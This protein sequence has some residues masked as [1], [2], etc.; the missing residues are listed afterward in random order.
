MPITK[1]PQRDSNFKNKIEGRFNTEVSTLTRETERRGQFEKLHMNNNQ[2]F[3]FIFIKGN[4]RRDKRLS[5][6]SVICM[7]PFMVLKIK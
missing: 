7:R 1:R 6:T 3:N 2:H 5:S 4:Q